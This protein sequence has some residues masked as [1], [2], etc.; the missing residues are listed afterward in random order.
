VGDE[1][2]ALPTESGVP[3][4]SS[5]AP[6]HWERTLA[7]ALAGAAFGASLC[8]TLLVSSGFFGPLYSGRIEARLS[9]V[10]AWL[11]VFAF[12]LS[13]QFSFTP[14]RDLLWLLWQFRRTL[15]VAASAGVVLFLLR[16]DLLRWFSCVALADTFF[17]AD[18]EHTPC[19]PSAGRIVHGTRSA[20]LLAQLRLV[21]AALI[22]VA[23]PFAAAELW[24]LVA[25]CANSERARR[26]T[27]AFGLA[28]G[29]TAM[30]AAFLCVRFL[31]PAAFHELLGFAGS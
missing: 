20:I 13:R 6:R 30:L 27:V 26:L 31:A 5:E 15:I 24:S 18:P 23:A 21:A 14:G 10:Y 9:A 11:A 28:A 25:R 12:W 4:T 19:S 7:R 2:S 29:G 8:F 22:V 17:L 3:A 1:Q 16:Q